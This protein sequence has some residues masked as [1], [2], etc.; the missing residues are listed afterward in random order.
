[1]G[2]ATHCRPRS[3]E[4]QEFCHFEA[5]PNAQNGFLSQT[6]DPLRAQTRDQGSE[7]SEDQ[8]GS[9]A[10]IDALPW[11]TLS[12]AGAFGNTY[13]DG[14]LE[15]EEVDNVQVVYEETPEGRL[16]H[17]RYVALGVTLAL[18]LSDVQILDAPQLATSSRPPERRDRGRT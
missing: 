12:H 3:G 1:V 4:W 11:K 8:S 6:Q 16:S 5:A 10:T 14:I 13:D 15:F 2:N 18:A 9:S 7:K 17:S